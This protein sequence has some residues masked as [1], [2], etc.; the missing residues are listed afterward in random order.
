MIQL[1]TRCHN[2]EV[3]SFWRF[4]MILEE[5]TKFLSKVA[6]FG[7]FETWNHIKIFTKFVGSFK[8][9]VIFEI[10]YRP[11]ICYE[12][13]ARV[14][15]CVFPFVRWT[16]RLISWDDVESW[17]IS[18]FFSTLIGRNRPEDFYVR[19]TVINHLPWFALKTVLQHEIID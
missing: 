4:L 6:R 12:S 7:P 15:K 18:H 3:H 13:I 19:K 17:K 8:N 9:Q 2:V 1:V 14:Y 16:L 11:G 10:D 5:I